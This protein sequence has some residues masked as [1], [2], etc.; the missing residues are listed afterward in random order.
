MTAVGK[1]KRTKASRQTRANDT[2]RPRQWPGTYDPTA[3]P[4]D[5]YLNTSAMPGHDSDFLAGIAVQAFQMTE[6]GPGMPQRDPQETRLSTLADEYQ[7]T[8]AKIAEML[9]TTAETNGLTWAADTRLATFHMTPEYNLVLID[10]V[11]RV[12]PHFYVSDSQCVARTS[13]GQRCRNRLAHGQPGRWTVWQ[14]ADEDS[15]YVQGFDLD[16]RDL[17]LGKDR[18]AKAMKSRFLAQRCWL[19]REGGENLV[20]PEWVTYDHPVHRPMLKLIDP[21]RL[22]GANIVPFPA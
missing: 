17:L 13:A 21:Q 18:S 5:N 12:Y 22:R 14:L 6:T 15:A 9:R 8:P 2:S 4:W 1:G 3:S 10:K 11:M 16:G 20:E 19:H 7:T